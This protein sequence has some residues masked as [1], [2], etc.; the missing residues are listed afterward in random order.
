M[1]IVLVTFV[2]YMALF[3]IKHH[4]VSKIRPQQLRLERDLQKLFENNLKTLLNVDFL[5]SEYVTSFGWRIDSLG[6]D[7][8]WSPVIIEYKRGQNNS[9]INQ[10]LSYLKWLLDHKADFE[11]LCNQKGF[12]LDINWDYP[13]VLC[14]AES[15]SKFDID[16]MEI[17]PIKIE[18]YTYKL[19][20]NNILQLEREANPEKVK[21][22]TSKII[23]KEQKE[24]KLQK[25]YTLDMHKQGKSEKILSL[26]ETV[27]EKVLSIDKDIIEEPLKLY[28]AYKNATNFVDIEIQQKNLK[29]YLNLPTWTIKEQ[30]PFLRDLVT[31]KK[32]G[33]WGNWDYLIKMSDESYLE[34]VFRLIAQAYSYN[35]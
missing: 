8:D 24:E 19:Y 32:I 10:A 18:L 21:I 6:I 12:S 34:E 4:S 13:R 28:I 3:S 1:C 7:Q 14:I 30:Y 20:E 27:R 5:A 31:P 35:S 22:S 16:T 9:V 26:F 15:Y 11:K 33:H 17:L 23:K 2:Y 29:I 25:D